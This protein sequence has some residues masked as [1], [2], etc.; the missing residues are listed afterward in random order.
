MVCPLCVCISIQRKIGP[1]CWILN[2][3]LF[4]NPCSYSITSPA[5]NYAIIQVVLEFYEHKY[6]GNK[7]IEVKIIT[8]TVTIPKIT[9]NW[10]HHDI[11]GRNKEHHHGD[12]WG[13][14]QR[15]RNI[16]DLLKY[17]MIINWINHWSPLS[18]ESRMEPNYKYFEIDG[19]QLLFKWNIQFF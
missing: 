7:N 15:P 11:H 16:K 8:R 1:L 2:T 19:V 17:R 4:Y 13:Q 5:Y 3:L 10:G 6:K 18:S 14:E 12:P 9:G